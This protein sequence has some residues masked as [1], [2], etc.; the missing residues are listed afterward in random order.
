[1]DVGF[2]PTGTEV[3]MRYMQSWEIEDICFEQGHA[4]GLAEGKEEIILNMKKKGYTI[5][6]IA[7]VTGKSPEEITAI[8]EKQE[9]ALV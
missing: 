8:I 7:D 1:V 4:S 5:E 3:E 2:K 9:S 6:Q